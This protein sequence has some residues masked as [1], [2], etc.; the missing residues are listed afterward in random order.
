MASAIASVIVHDVTNGGAPLNDANESPTIA[1][2]S[3]GNGIG[4]SGA[5]AGAL[6]WG[7]GAL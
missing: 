4:N 6:A 7:G 1:C 3:N 5:G 2:D